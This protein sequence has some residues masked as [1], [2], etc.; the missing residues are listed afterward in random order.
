[1]ST[2][3]PDNFGHTLQRD[4]DIVAFTS[5][6]TS[7]EFPTKLRRISSVHVTPVQTSSAALGAAVT[8]SAQPFYT[9]SS[10]TAGSY[11]STTGHIT[12]AKTSAGARVLKINRK[13][14]TGGSNDSGLTICVTLL[15]ESGTDV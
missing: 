13:V 4:S 8:F 5:T 12:P 14:E 1:M 3:Q 11:N 9:P 6:A 2:N 10:G 15:G 7:L